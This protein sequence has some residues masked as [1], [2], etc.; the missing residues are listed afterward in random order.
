MS[1]RRNFIEKTVTTIAG[2]AALPLLGRAAI[3]QPQTLFDGESS[4][5]VG[6]AGFTFA[7]FDVEK[8]IAILKGKQMML[9]G[10]IVSQT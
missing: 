8:S 1:T 6:M 4:L 2:A 5:S 10:T 9:P 7:K 3:P